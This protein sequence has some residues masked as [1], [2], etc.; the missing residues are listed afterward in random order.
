MTQATRMTGG[1]ALVKSNTA[2]GVDTIFGLPGV[3]LDWFFNALHDE[4]NNIRVI[5]SRH[6]QSVA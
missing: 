4:G 1:Q 2:H 3:Q 6:E 5:N